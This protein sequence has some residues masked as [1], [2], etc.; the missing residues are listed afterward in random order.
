[1]ACAVPAMLTK[2]FIQGRAGE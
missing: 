2:P 1:M